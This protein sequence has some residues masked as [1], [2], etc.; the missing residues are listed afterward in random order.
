MMGADVRLKD[1]GVIES[2]RGATRAVALAGDPLL[3]ELAPLLIKVKAGCRVSFGRVYSL[4]SARLF[5]IILRIKSDR[6]EAEEILQE[7]YL[8]VWNASDQFDASR[9]QAIHWLAG[10]AHHGAID[11]L[12]RQGRRPK[13]TL[14]AD[15]EEDPYSGMPSEW[16]SPPETLFLQ[17]STQALHRALFEL[18]NEQREKLMLAFFDGLS[19][20]EIAARLRQPLGSVKSSLRRSLMSMKQRLADHR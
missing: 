13:A 1:K 16:P 4:S 14:R 15:P 7:V 8:K 10:I 9:G 17:R 11:G 18:P 3:E 2:I 19:H 20:A 12:R 5:G 6:A